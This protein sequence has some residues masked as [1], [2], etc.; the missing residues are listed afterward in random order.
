MPLHTCARGQLL[1]SE[2]EHKAL[3]M[4]K[5]EEI[6]RRKAEVEMSGTDIKLAF[7][8]RSIDKVN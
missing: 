7:T 1:L 2:H 4:S 3:Q 8:H 5:S 6:T